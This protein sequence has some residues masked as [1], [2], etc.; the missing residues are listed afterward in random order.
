MGS[1]HFVLI[2]GM[3]PPLFV[4]N[5]AVA[6]LGSADIGFCISVAM[7]EG[8]TRQYAA[9]LQELIAPYFE[10]AASAGHRWRK[11]EGVPGLPLIVDF[12]AAKSEDTAVSPDGGLEPTSGAEAR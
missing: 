5:A 11:R 4:P 7:T 2:G 9:S 1:R 12:L 6:H 10:P 3:V 8:A